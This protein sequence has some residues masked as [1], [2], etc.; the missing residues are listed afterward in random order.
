MDELNA[1]LAAALTKL[2]SELAPGR[3]SM[4][5][6]N[7]ADHHE[8]E[9]L[10]ANPRAARLLAVLAPG[11]KG[12]TV[13]LF[14]G[15]GSV[16]EIPER[17]ARYTDHPLLG[18]FTALCEAVIKGRF[19]EKVRIKGSDDVVASSGTVNVPPAVTAHWR[20]LFYNPFRPTRTEE[21]EYEAY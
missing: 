20:Q 6:R 15:K 5:S 9:L 12:A 2:A 21:L 7:V 8:L 18:E 17:G 4:S 3:A 10:P 1:E 13:T 19:K 14:L 11:N 16:F